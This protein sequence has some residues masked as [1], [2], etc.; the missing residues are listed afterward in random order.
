M[1]TKELAKTVLEI[2]PDDYDFYI[3]GDGP[4]WDEVSGKIDEYGL[5][6]NVHMMGFQSNIPSCLAHMDALLITSDHE[7]LPMNLL[8]SMALG[9]FVIAHGTGGIESV[10]DKD[11]YGMVLENQNIE[12]F[13]KGVLAF[14]EGKEKLQLTKY[15]SQDRVVS[16]YSSAVCAEKHIKLY[17][18]LSIRC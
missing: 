18:E 13:A 4:L 10:I 15:L 1:K 14:K 7:G 12:N 17:A 16:Q 3:F 2:S 9:V 8:E 5:A 6:D 11:G